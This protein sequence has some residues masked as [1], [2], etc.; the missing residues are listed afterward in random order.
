[1]DNKSI[2]PSTRRDAVCADTTSAL[3]LSNKIIS[4]FDLTTAR[5]KENLKIFLKEKNENK[6]KKLVTVLQT[7]NQPTNQSTNQSIY[8]S[9]PSSYFSSFSSL[10]PLPLLTFHKTKKSNNKI[11]PERLLPSCYLHERS[12]CEDMS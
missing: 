5:E 10:L 1:M 7:I 2:T 9:T 11:I 8:S 12:I 4:R 3:T 6:R